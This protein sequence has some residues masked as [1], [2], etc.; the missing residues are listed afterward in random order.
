MIAAHSLAVADASV[1]ESP[2]SVNAAARNAASH[3]RTTKSSHE[4][5]VYAVIARTSGRFR[6]TR[7]SR[8]ARSPVVSG[9]PRVLASATG[10]AASATRPI[11]SAAPCQPNGVSR[12]PVA[13]N[14]SELPR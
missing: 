13:K 1:G 14:E 8:C 9:R 4:W 10:N 12:S 5:P 7:R 2:R 3:A 6:S 11:A